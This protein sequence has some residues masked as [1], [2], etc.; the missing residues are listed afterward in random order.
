MVSCASLLLLQMT[1]SI[2][3]LG[4]FANIASISSQETSHWVAWGMKSCISVQLVEDIFGGHLVPA[5]G[6]SQV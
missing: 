1:M 3:Y 6:P 4:P 2:H 5:P